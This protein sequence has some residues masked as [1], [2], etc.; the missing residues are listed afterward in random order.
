MIDQYLAVC[1]LVEREFERNRALHR[2]RIQCRPGCSDCCHQLFQITEIEAAYISLGVS[3]MEPPERDRLRDRAS[4][5]LDERRALV[6]RVGEPEAWGN[7][8]A[9]GTRLAC[10]ALVDGICTIYEF[11]PLICRKFGMPLFNPD[12]PHRVYA[13]ELNFRDGEEIEDPPLIQ[14]QTSI[15]EQWRN[16]QIRY[17]DAGLPR[18]REPLTVARALVEDFT[19][20]LAP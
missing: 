2:N 6:S 10:P 5:Y 14:I 9:R 7:L 4:V 11:R 17:N 18:E 19:P 1:G 20:M 16:V 3:R 15:H 12:R 8:P 13:C